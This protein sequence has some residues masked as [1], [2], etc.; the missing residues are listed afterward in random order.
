MRS[1]FAVFLGVSMIVALWTQLH[2][3]S[4]DLQEDQM[5]NTTLVEVWSI[6]KIMIFI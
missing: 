4:L 2:G 6:V 1:V 5:E 3:F